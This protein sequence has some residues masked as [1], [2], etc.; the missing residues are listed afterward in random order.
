MR[1]PFFI[2]NELSF[3]WALLNI[4]RFQIAR[5][6]SSG[7]VK[8][9]GD[10]FGFPGIYGRSGRIFRKQNACRKLYVV[11]LNI[12]RLR[13]AKVFRPAKQKRDRCPAFGANAICRQANPTRLRDSESR[14]LTAGG[15]IAAGRWFAEQ[16]RT[17]NACPTQ[18]TERCSALT[19]R[20][21]AA[22]FRFWVQR[23]DSG[24]FGVACLRYKG[25]C[26]RLQNDRLCKNSAVS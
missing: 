10:S 23:T 8:N 5:S 1:K 4:R 6:F 12:R 9:P 25:L 18:K 19:R 20:Q 13:I 3:L 16:T 14:R 22:A 15:W 11:A 2:K 21:R 26:C 24:Q 17:N 7:S